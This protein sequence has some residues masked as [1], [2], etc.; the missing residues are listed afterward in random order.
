MCVRE[1]PH[2]CLTAEDVRAAQDGLETPRGC[3]QPPW[4]RLPAPPLS[5]ASADDARPYWDPMAGCFWRDVTSISPTRAP[6]SKV[7]RTRALRLYAEA[8]PC[9]QVYHFTE[10]D[11]IPNHITYAWPPQR[12]RGAATLPRPTAHTCACEQRCDAREGGRAHTAQILRVT[13]SVRGAAPRQA[14]RHHR[15]R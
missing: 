13:G 6:D 4:W 11:P 5:R 3:G 1:P 12:A 14:G 2:A 9:A 10:V 15:R 8:M 7:I